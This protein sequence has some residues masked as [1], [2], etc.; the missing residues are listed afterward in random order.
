[1]KEKLIRSLVCS[2]MMMVLAIL[3]QLFAF[4]TMFKFSAQAMDLMDS[5]NFDYFDFSTDPIDKALCLQ[6]SS[7]TTM[8]LPSRLCKNFKVFPG[9]TVCLD[10]LI[11][12]EFRDCLVYS[13][14]ILNDWRFDA[15][16]AKLGCEVHSFDPTVDFPEKLAP[17]VTFHKIGLF[18]GDR[19]ESFSVNGYKS[20]FGNQIAGDMMHL[21]E[22]VHMLGH[23]HRN[24]S[25]LKIDCEGCEWEVF[26][27]MHRLHHSSHHNKDS[28]L[29]SPL[30]RV[31]QL[32]MEMH[33]SISLGMNS[34][35]RIELVKHTYDLLFSKRFNHGLFSKFYVKENDGYK[36]DQNL[37][38][39]LVQ[40]GFPPKVCCREIGFI[41]SEDHH[42]S[43]LEV[44]EINNIREGDLLKCEHPG[45]P[46]VYLVQ[47]GTRREFPN[48]NTFLQMGFDFGNVKR[49]RDDIVEAMP[50]GE[51]LP[52]K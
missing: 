32:L 30:D 46:S 6:N 14:G 2:S 12:N 51:G 38:D 44:M 15:E 3:Q 41:R 25:V 10:E 20:P 1:M 13:V 40:R 9:W 34:D 52:T 19:N 49:L 5:E 35:E 45:K 26:G 36:W 43:A 22:I 24:I 8:C 11:E 29:K 7:L 37:M 4:L 23:E 42:I 50:L 48:G 17:N 16:M 47:N 21:S 28:A 33:F 39:K 27:H 18:G 31:R